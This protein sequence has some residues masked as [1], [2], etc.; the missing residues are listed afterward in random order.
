MFVKLGFLLRRKSLG[1]RQDA[2]GLGIEIFLVVS[3]PL[4]DLTGFMGQIHFCTGGK[5]GRD[6]NNAATYSAFGPNAGTGILP[7]KMVNNGITDL[8]TEFIRMPGGHRLGRKH[9]IISHCPPF[10]F[11][12][13]CFR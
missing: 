2:T 5:T 13:F 10:V 6:K 4:D 12:L 9:E 3:H 7:Q 1:R 11:S 8:V